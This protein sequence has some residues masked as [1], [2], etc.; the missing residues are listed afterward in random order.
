[1]D[2][3]VR[4]T[5]TS[6]YFQ[7]GVLL[8]I[9][10]WLIDP[11]IDT[12][13]LQVG[14]LSEL[15]FRP[16]AH[17]A[18]MRSVI[19][20]LIL[21]FSYLGARFINHIQA[22]EHTL[23]Q[24]QHIIDKA[25]DR[26]ALIDIELRHIQVNDAYSHPFN[27][28]AQQMV[29]RSL[30]EFFG[31]R[32]VDSV[33][34]PYAER[35]LRGRMTEFKAWFDK[36]EAHPVCLGFMLIPWSDQDSENP[37]FILN[38]RDLTEKEFA[39][40]RLR[41]SEEHFRTLF[42]RAPVCIH[43]IDRQGC[44]LSMNPAGLKML[45]LSDESEIQGL[46]Y[47]DV[48]AED[49]REY[50][51]TLLQRAWAGEAVYF[52]FTALDKSDR[53][54]FESSFIPIK[55]DSNHTVW[56]M[57]V[58]QNQTVR[59]RTEQSLQ[60][61][62]QY[63]RFLVENNP[64]M[65]FTISLDGEILSVNRFGAETLGYTQQD[66]IGKPVLLLFDQSQHATAQHWVDK[67]LQHPNQIIEWEIPKVHRDGHTVYVKES[68]YAV[69]N[70]DGE[71]VILIVCRDI[72]ETHRAE[73]AL[74]T[75]EARYRAVVEDMPALVCT[76]FRDGEIVLVNAA[77]CQYFQKSEQQL[78]GSNFLDLVAEADRS[79]VMGHIASLSRQQPVKTIEHQVIAPDGSTRWQRWTNR[80]L[81]DEGDKPL[82][83][84]S[85]GEDV[86]ERKQSQMALLKRTNHL[87]ENQ[88]ILFQLA[89]EDFPDAASAFNRIV[90]TSAR[91]LDADRVSVWLFNADCSRVD[92]QVLYVQGVVGQSD[93]SLS[94]SEYR[95]YFNKLEE[96]NY[97]SELDAAASTITAELNADY[98]Q[99][100][101]VCSLMDVP[102]RVDGKMVGIICHETVGKSK[103]WSVEDLDFGKSVADLCAVVIASDERKR[104]ESI[105]EAIHEG[106]AQTTGE[107]FFLELTR[108][109]AQSLGLRY[110]L[111][112]RLI[113]D[114]E[115]ETIAV[116]N[117]DHW[118][119]NFNYALAET[120]CANV[121][122]KNTCIYPSKVTELFP[123]D[124]LLAEM[125]V[126]GYLGTPLRNLSGK[127]LGLM[128]LMHDKPI[129]Q[130]P[131]VTSVLEV[132]AQR[133][134]S[135]LGRRISE[136]E[137]HKLSRAVESSATSILI[138]DPD[139]TI[140]Y[141]NPGFSSNTGFSRGEAVGQKVWFFKSDQTPDEMYDAIC[142]E[143]E[144]HGEWKGEINNR[145]KDGRPYWDRVIVSA[146]K[147]TDDQISHYIFMQDD[148]TR[149]YELAEE[150]NFQARHDA[151]TGL[152]NR[153]EFE[154]QCGKLLQRTQKDQTEHALCFMDLDQFKVVNDTCGHAA[155][156]ELLRQIVR[157][158]HKK[159]RKRDQLARMGGDEFALLMEHCNLEQA[160]RVAES[161]H[162]SVKDYN[163]SWEGHAFRIG[164]SIGLVAIT[165][166]VT[167]FT[168]LLKQADSAC[169]MAKELGRNRIHVYHTED[170]DLAK[171]HG[172]MQWLGRIH[173]AIDED[174]FM[175]Y[176]QPIVTTR[177]RADQPI[178]HYELLLRLRDEE[179]KVVP[180]GA[181]LPAAERYYL[182]YSLDRWVISKAFNSLLTHPDFLN[183]ID[184][185]SINLSG[186]SLV[187]R[188]LLDFIVTELLNTGIDGEKICFEI[189][190][191][192]A[193]ANL[194]LANTF[195]S[196]LK[197]LGCHFS[198]DDFGSGLSSFGYL[199]NL[200]VDF[201]KI[202]GMFVRN[203]VNDE[204]DFAMVKSI[205]EIGRVMG[206]QTI[207][208]FVENDAIM[209]KLIEIGVDYAQGYGLGK[210]APLDTLLEMDLEPRKQQVTH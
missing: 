66:L 178:R 170:T 50:V 127:T 7:L 118:D 105:M 146:V 108:V 114:E 62:E 24:Y 81:F 70:P 20:V 135:E 80:A 13:V 38:L 34:R 18:Y 139:G 115:I 157:I 206:M 152:I 168:E 145:K 21:L 49:E 180:P 68:G 123:N 6:G 193:I 130:I 67:C 103:D 94:V 60:K 179:G 88:S 1:M 74:K 113:D 26:M 47:L 137:L 69:T 89:K 194:N 166:E 162:K 91:Q 143:V 165:A 39:Q 172:E 102:I 53:Q 32:F 159:I 110:A 97:V 111:V 23:Q 173:T 58:T 191:T 197:G 147:D 61:S 188:E 134:G 54:Y 183:S 16:D 30:G 126:E 177:G 4:A 76:F 116:W 78:L 144:R 59:K 98:P 35:C 56:L 207:A 72:T 96:S 71:E 150:L 171:R 187:N 55:D 158:F 133:A 45:H 141:V 11:I 36:L 204:I 22:S 125:G 201:L 184:T 101:N 33:L 77:Y 163:F 136:Q 48:V 46:P 86:T 208:E 17:E 5:L 122:A 112:G 185:V 124:E 117:H 51:G 90:E 174:R 28:S 119:E 161:L 189:T 29:G 52:E 200:K 8:A 79:M 169:Y 27:L 199:K 104:M 87:L 151:L 10:V 164:V 40:K 41:D 181:F 15:M 44:L 65:Q 140:E 73:Q 196:T 192:A 132:F 195:I 176:A 75:S 82:I 205:H 63:L 198:L 209:D 85:I 120:P 138:T 129:A 19:S 154:F 153:R 155:G 128:M 3:E 182:M 107:M 31:E 149:E 131:L 167:D 121:I 9:L 57:G 92:C 175:L 106:T 25:T 2:R 186:Q 210:P 156:D 109:L 42:E 43:E 84:Q 12:Y 203:I 93:I 99:P 95:E 202:D 148:V 160:K 37:V 100:Y 142:T 14:T 190:E 64:I 83:Y